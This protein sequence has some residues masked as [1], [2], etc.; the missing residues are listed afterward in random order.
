MLNLRRTP[1]SEPTNMLR[2]FGPSDTPEFD[3]E[4][5]LAL[6]E[7]DQGLAVISVLVLG[8]WV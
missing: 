3:D 8:R 6:L 1:T 7:T 5:T 2:R 4:K